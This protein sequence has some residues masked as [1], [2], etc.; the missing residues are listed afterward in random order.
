MPSDPARALDDIHDH[1]V[2][3][4]V[5]LGD[6]TL[7]QFIEDRLRVYAVVRCLE[8]ISEA[9]R[10]LP[11]DMLDRHPQIP[12]HAIKAS[13]NVYRHQYEDV[14]ERD[15]FNTVRHHLPIL[16]AVIRAER[17]EAS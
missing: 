1:I 15:V 10:R 13:G 2:L 6:L 17:G 5:W 3:A 7:D 14:L 8:V 11:T 4:T 9:A 16:A 12:W